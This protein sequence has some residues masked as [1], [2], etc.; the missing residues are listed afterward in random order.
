MAI[1]EPA[2]QQPPIAA[3]E[4]P[5]AT[6][7]RWRG[8]LHTW[9]AVA[10]LPAGIALALLASRA[11]VRV[12]VLVYAVGIGMMF[13]VSA[14]YHRGRWTPTVRRM[15]GR[16]DHSTIFLGIAATYT[17][18]VV[19]GLQGTLR[20]VML[21]AVWFGAAAGITLQWLPVKPPRW[22]FTACY[23]AAGWPAVGVLP[24][25]V[26]RLGWLTFAFIVAGGLAY[27][28][29]AVV[30]ARKKPDPSPRTFGFHEVFHSCTIVGAG[31]HFTAVLLAVVAHG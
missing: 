21:F 31:A 14:M 1:D 12:G 2:L 19:I 15:F 4:P 13:V 3:P 28:A 24:Q 16:L 9:A 6:K 7:P 29:G 23:L 22:L 11:T 8:V 27:T 18:V 30:Y 20:V 10:V 17:P 26:R 25:L 5:A